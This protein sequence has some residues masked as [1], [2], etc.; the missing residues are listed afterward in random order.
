MKVLKNFKPTNEAIKPTDY[1]S[2]PVVKIIDSEDVLMDLPIAAL[3]FG[4][5]YLKPV[6][7]G[8]YK[9]IPTVYEESE[10]KQHLARLKLFHFAEDQGKLTEVLPDEAKIHVRLPKDTIVDQL[11]YQDGQIIWAKPVKQPAEEG[12]EGHGNN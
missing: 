5:S 11:I 12:A 4:K 9:G 3:E 1:E 7:Y 2:F 8:N 6:V 10:V